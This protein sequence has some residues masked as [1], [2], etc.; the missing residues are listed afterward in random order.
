[1]MVDSLVNEEYYDAYMNRF[2][3]VIRQ[4]N[5]IFASSEFDAIGVAGNI[6]NGAMV[7]EAFF[8][9]HI[10]PYEM[11]ALKPLIERKKPTVYHNCGVAKNLYPCYRTMGVT[12]W[13]TISQPPQGDNDLQEAKMY[14]GSDIV[15]CGTLDQVNFLKNATPD[16]IYDLAARTV[17]I[18]KPDAHYIFAASDFL[19]KG[20]PIENI[21][22]M[23]EG[24]KSTAAYE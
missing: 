18:G 9:E 12:C 3:E 20:T 11:H 6:A 23:I 2:A 17:L 14:F 15:L 1:M 7:G 22:A 19:E 16:E 21:R 5:E 24:A 8:A 13:E 4:S 10:L